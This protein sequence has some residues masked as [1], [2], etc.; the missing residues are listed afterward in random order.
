MQHRRSVGEG[1]RGRDGVGLLC[2]AYKGAGWLCLEMLTWDGNQVELSRKED[3]D[4]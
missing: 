4:R 1:E 2:L 3:S